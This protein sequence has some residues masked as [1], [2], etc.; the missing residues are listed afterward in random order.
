M[1][2]RRCV[3][4]LAVASALTPG[5]TVRARREL[6][7]PHCRSW[8]V[9]AN[10][11]SYAF[12]LGLMATAIARPALYDAMAVSLKPVWLAVVGLAGLIGQGI[13]SLRGAA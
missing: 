5:L 10:L 2:D 11:V 1:G 6:S 13:E 3:G 7:P 12:L 9:V 4:A 8:A